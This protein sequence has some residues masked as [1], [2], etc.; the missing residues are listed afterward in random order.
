LHVTDQ[1]VSSLVSKFM[2]I[3]P[4]TPEQIAA[5]EQRRKEGRLKGFR[6][7]EKFPHDYK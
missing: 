4:L 3:R 7:K 6:E 5:G 2:G 1:S